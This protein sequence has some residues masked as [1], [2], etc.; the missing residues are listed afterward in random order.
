MK[1]AIDMEMLYREI[2]V[3][4][5][6]A[7]DNRLARL[8]ESAIALMAENGVDELTFG[9][10][11]KRAKMA[12][13]H[14]VYYFPS[15]DQLVDSVISFVAHSAERIIT[16]DLLEVGSIEAMLDS[17]VVACFHWLKKYPQHA[18]VM[19]LFYYESSF[20]K[21]RKAFHSTIRTAGRKRIEAILRLDPKLAS[22][23]PRQ[24]EVLARA[25]AAVITGN[26]IE[27]FTTDNESFEALLKQ[28]KDTVRILVE[29]APK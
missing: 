6:K 24:R 28:T 16:T 18:T 12:R 4:R 19:L 15:R 17:Y 23:T 26:L 25:V 1:H 13:S 27:A 5:P 14:V 2:L 22:L 10:L 21:R 9:A 20:K 11:G 8:M 7:Q 29:N 3:F